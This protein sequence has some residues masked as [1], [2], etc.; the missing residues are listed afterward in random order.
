MK[1]FLV[2]FRRLPLI[3]YLDIFSETLITMVLACATFC[4]I[5]LK[6]CK[7]CKIHLS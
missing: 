6:L 7:C 1:S 2:Y 3:N 5:T 4:L